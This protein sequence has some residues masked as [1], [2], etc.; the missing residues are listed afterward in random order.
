MQPL[1]LVACLFKLRLRLLQPGHRASVGA[2]LGFQLGAD[3]VYGLVCGS[4]LATQLLHRGQ[5]LGR[6]LLS[7]LP[8]M[9]G[10][11]LVCMQLNSQSGQLPARRGRGMPPD[12]GDCVGRHRLDL[13]RQVRMLDLYPGLA[14]QVFPKL[15]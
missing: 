14:A 2:S 3:L 10:A 4:Q 5:R 11:F 8:L 6:A 9:Q 15:G 1:L 7:L 13:A 12:L